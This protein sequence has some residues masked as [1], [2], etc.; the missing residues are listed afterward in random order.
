LATAGAIGCARRTA[1]SELERELALLVEQQAPALLALPG[2][3]TA[4]VERFDS[5][6]KL[7]LHAVAAP[8][9]VRSDRQQRDRLNR[10]GNRQLYCAL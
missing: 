6:A 1:C 4:G 10:S 9:D 2:C 3:A 7:A 5:D 8:V